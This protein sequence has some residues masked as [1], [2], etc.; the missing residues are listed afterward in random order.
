MSVRFRA[1][2]VGVGAVVVGLHLVGLLTWWTVDRGMQPPRKAS[3][4]DA[5]AVWLPAFSPVRTLPTT[6]QKRQQQ[7][8]S[9]DSPR[10]ADRAV[11]PLAK[12]VASVELPAS[13]AQVQSAAEGVTAQPPMAPASALNL[14]LSGKTLSTLST[15]GFAAQSPFQGRLPATVERRVAQAFAETGPWTEERI[16]NDHVRFRRGTTCVTMSRPQSAII[17]PFSEASGRLPWRASVSDCP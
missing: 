11:P 3:V 16:D 14:K 2:K 9:S 10:P 4:P 15:P 12:W 1:R 13:A 5:V 6:L 17:D 7:S 8:G